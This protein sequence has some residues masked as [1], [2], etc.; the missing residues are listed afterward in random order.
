MFLGYPRE[1]CGY[2]C[3]NPL[4]GKVIISKDVV[5]L[6]E[7]FDQNLGLNLN[8]LCEPNRLENLDDFCLVLKKINVIDQ[9]D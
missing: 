2:I 6:E 5:F 8:G 4:N 7:V 3:L 1:Y 9:V